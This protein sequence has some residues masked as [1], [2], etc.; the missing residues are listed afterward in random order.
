MPVKQHANVSRRDLV[1]LAYLRE[2]SENLHTFVDTLNGPDSSLR[3]IRSDVL[4]DV[5]D[6]LSRLVGP[7]YYCHDR[8]RRAISSFEIVRFASESASPRSTIT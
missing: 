6:P 3:I 1:A 7:R 2:L 8:M 4:E 5:L